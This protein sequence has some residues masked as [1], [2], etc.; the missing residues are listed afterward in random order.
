MAM[1]HPGFYVLRVPARSM[2]NHALVESRP[3]QQNEDWPD[4]YARKMA[5]DW[6][7]YIQS[8]HPKDLV[9]VVERFAVPEVA[10]AG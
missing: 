10:D 7:D 5:D 4:G 8:E 2:S 6:R 3:F 1:Y 9:F